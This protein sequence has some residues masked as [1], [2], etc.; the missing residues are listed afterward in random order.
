MTSILIATLGAEPQV[1]SLAT[2]LLLRMH[3]SPVGV[4]VLH[5]DTSYPPIGE[6]LARLE[7]VFAETPSLPPLSCVPVPVVDVLSPRELDLFADVLFDRVR[8]AQASGM[9][10]HLLLAGGRKSMTMVGMSVAHLLLGAGDMV[11]YLYS[12]PELRASERMLLREGD[13]AELIAVPLPR[14]N[15]ASPRYTPAGRA[16]TRLAAVA[17]AQRAAAEQARIFFEQDLTR[18]E[19]EIAALLVRDYLTVAQIARQLHKSPKTI[20]NQLTAIYSKLESR[21]GLEPDQVLKREF[22]RRELAPYLEH[23][24]QSPTKI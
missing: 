6:A 17:A 11:W 22:L 2:Q 16:Q 3:A 1:V 20:T 23:T 15:L 8:T 24:L 4:H 10:V 7:R 9:Q 21:F 13:H 12:A 5:T 19:R 18:A 14:A